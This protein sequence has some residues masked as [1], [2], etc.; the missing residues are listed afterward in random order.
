MAL[1]L[2]TITGPAKADDSSPKGV[3]ETL[4]SASRLKNSPAEYLLKDIYAAPPDQDEITLRIPSRS[5]QQIV[6]TTRA[7]EQI[8]IGLPFGYQG[9]AGRQVYGRSIG[10]DNKNGS[11]TVVLPKTDGSVQVATIIDGVSAPTSFSY[12]LSLPEGGR[13]VVSSSGLVLILD[14]QGQY[15]AAVAPPWAIDAKGV[16]VPTRFE[17]RGNLLVQSVDHL[18]NKVTYPVVA[19]PWFGVDMIDRTSWNRTSE[20]SPTLS[21]YPSTWG[22]TVAFA[23]TYPFTSGLI[24]AVDQLSANAAWSET[25]AKTVRAWNPNPE[26]PSMRAQFDCHFFWVSKRDPRKASWNLDSLRPYGSLLVQA[27]KNCNVE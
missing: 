14:S 9:S 15:A 8:S 10:F 27:Q 16:K 7:K 17:L 11:T 18:I 6:L 3:L 19:D 4:T 21:V 2:N 25:L 1:L 23:T 12:P 5:S 22:R 26:T 13:A 20:F 24:R